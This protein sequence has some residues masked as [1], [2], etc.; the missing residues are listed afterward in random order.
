MCIIY[1]YLVFRRSC[2]SR[3][4]AAIAAHLQVTFALK[5]SGCAGLKCCWRQ[6]RVRCWQRR[7]WPACSSL[8]SATPS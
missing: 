2:A 3:L 1:I 8:A 5:G 7:S 4:H 6:L